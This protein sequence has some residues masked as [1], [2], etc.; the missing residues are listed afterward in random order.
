MMMLVVANL[1]HVV[2]APKLY[3]L[4]WSRW[5][6]SWIEYQNNFFKEEREK[7][8]KKKLGDKNNEM[9]KK[10]QRSKEDSFLKITYLRA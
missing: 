8:K 10:R 5:I 9:K 7:G 2:Y 6:L 1:M 3:S 4:K